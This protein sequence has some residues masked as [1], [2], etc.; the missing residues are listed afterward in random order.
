MRN[1]WMMVWI[2]VFFALPAYAGDYV[3]NGDGTIT[4]NSTGLMWQKAAPE[5]KIN[6]KEAL[7]YCEALKL[8]GHT[9]WRLPTIKELRS[10]VD[11]A[12]YHPAIDKIVFPN[13]QSSFYWSGTTNASSTDTDKAWSVNFNYGYDDDNNKSSDHHVRA[14]RSVQ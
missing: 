14:V 8:G 6:W 9:D 10:I 11:Y 12:K 5:N 7:A 4:D 3:D 13:T 2:L 1:K